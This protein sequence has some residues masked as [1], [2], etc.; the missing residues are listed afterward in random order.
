[1]AATEQS[2]VAFQ[3]AEPLI[4]TELVFIRDHPALLT[5]VFD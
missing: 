3:L 4:A 1:V 5:S 2:R